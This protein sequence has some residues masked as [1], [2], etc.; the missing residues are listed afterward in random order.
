MHRQSSVR[1][2]NDPHTYIVDVKR[3]ACRF[4]IQN[5]GS[6]STYTYSNFKTIFK[7]SGLIYKPTNFEF[8]EFEK[9]QQTEEYM[10]Q[11]VRYFAAVRQN[12]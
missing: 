11:L 1:V 9:Y 2:K 6:L 3:K 5:C 4:I 12:I 8:N 10:Q 7:R